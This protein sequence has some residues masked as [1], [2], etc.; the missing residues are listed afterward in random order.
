MKMALISTKKQASKQASKNISALKPTIQFEKKI[1]SALMFFGIHEW[2]KNF[3]FLLFLKTFH[4][5]D[6]LQKTF[7]NKYP[8]LPR[9]C[10]VTQ[11]PEE[12]QVFCAIPVKALTRRGW[13]WCRGR[14]RT[15]YDVDSERNSFGPS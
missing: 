2:G 9:I 3:I 15:P 14:E 8:K 4:F 11:Q 5:R 12:R 1:R 6:N 7:L 13:N 10:Q